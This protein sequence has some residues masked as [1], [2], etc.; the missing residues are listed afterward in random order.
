MERDEHGN[1]GEMV[2]IPLDGSYGCGPVAELTLVTRTEDGRE[3]EETFTIPYHLIDTKKLQAFCD[4]NLI[5]G[6]RVVKS[7]RPSPLKDLGL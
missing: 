6:F 7:G 3:K 1:E 2:R 5:L 4:I